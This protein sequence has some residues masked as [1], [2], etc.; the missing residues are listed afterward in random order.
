MSSGKWCIH[1]C[2]L[3][4]RKWQN[5][6]D[7][8]HD[9]MSIKGGYWSYLLVPRWPWVWQTRSLPKLWSTGLTSFDWQTSPTPVRR[10]TPLPLLLEVGGVGHPE[11]A[12][13]QSLGYTLDISRFSIGTKTLQELSPPT[14]WGI[15]HVH[16]HVKCMYMYSV[17]GV[18]K[19]N[20]KIMSFCN[21]EKLCIH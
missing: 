15:L 13:T 11:M 12:Q 5:S 6:H 7:S 8:S 18:R 2:L 16:I 21:N 1:G 3:N 14:R 19:W 10:P 17:W 9:I 20:G 4:W